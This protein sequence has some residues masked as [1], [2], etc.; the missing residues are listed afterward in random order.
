MSD[1]RAAI[2]KRM[3]TILSRPDLRFP[4]QHTEA[5]TPATRMVVTDAAGGYDELALRFGQELEALHGTYEICETDTE[6]RLALINRLMLWIDQDKKERKGAVVVTGQEQ[7]VLA[8]DPDLL[9]IAG[10]GPALADLGLKLVAPTDLRAGEQR[11]K[12]RHIRYGITGV[13][14]AMASTG[15]MLVIAG[16]GTSRAAS[17]LPFRHIALIPFSRL[18]RTLEEWLAEQRAAGALADLFHSRANLTLITGPSKSADIEMA[19]TLGVHGP[20]F[21]HAIL[22]DDSPPDDVSRYRPS[23]LFEDEGVDED[24]FDDEETSGGGFDDET[25]F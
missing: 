14:A 20:K 4:A 5:L 23:D 9:P 12:A 1:A 19:L 8:W 13:E 17:L 3:R 6:A 7:S 18:Y 11:E 2:L 24:G 25:S 10:I 16:K 22:F 15:S 21:V